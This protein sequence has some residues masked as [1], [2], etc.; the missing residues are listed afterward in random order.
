[1]K[2]FILKNIVL[3]VILVFTLISSIVLIFLIEGKRRTVAQ[4]MKDIDANVTTIESIDSARKPNSVAESET[5]IKA[6]TEAL[7]KKKP[8]LPLKSARI[9]NNILYQK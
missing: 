7:A 3:T 4:S 8:N 2:Q 5:K 1:M 9:T 6:D